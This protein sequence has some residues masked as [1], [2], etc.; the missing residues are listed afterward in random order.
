MGKISSWDWEPGQKTVVKSL[1]LLEGH[2]WQE[3]PYVSPDGETFVAIVKVGD[4][5]FSVRTNDSVWETT[6]EKIWYPKFSP[7][8]RLTAI[9]QQDME[10]VLVADGEAM[11]ETTDYI[12][13][14]L[15][16]ED[17]SVI[18]TM[19]KAME[20]YGMCV[21]GEPW[22]TLYENANMPALSKDGAHTAAVVQAESLAAADLEGFKRG[23]YTVAVDGEAWKGRYVNIWNP[24]FDEAGDSLAATCRTTVYDHTIVVDDKP[25]ATTYNQVWEPVFCPKD[26]GVA[27]PVRVAGK[28][29][30]AK[31]GQ[32]L[33]EPRYVQCFYLQYDASGEK[34]WSVVAT[35]YG[36]FTACVNN[37][38]WNETW[39][40]VSDLVVSPDGE[41]AAILASNCNEDFRIVVDGTPWAGTYDMAWPVVFSAD[42]KSVAAKVEKNGRF[43]ILVN[44]KSF[45]RDFD[46]VWP[47][48]FSEDGTK[49]LIRAIENNSYV[50]I[51]AEVCDF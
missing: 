29:G 38:A 45:E 21:N 20:Q 42:S 30:V 23:V 44:G 39:P 13:D 12:W 9:C 36:Q 6:F 37:A 2:E 51:V 28:W 7:D 48:I 19:Y 49:V 31:D 15:F 47:P 32:T 34:L 35:S 3:E 1:S 8:G 5:E 4:G 27:A 43:R 22:E 46:A 24:V 40:T 26:G 14:T 18:A 17:G 16:S 33:W 11:G 10:W 41:R 25:W 50:R